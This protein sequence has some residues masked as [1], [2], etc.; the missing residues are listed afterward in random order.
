L[1]KAFSFLADTINGAIYDSPVTVIMKCDEIRPIGLEVVRGFDPDYCIVAVQVFL[2]LSGTD[3]YGTTQFKSFD[4]YQN[5]VN[6][7]CRRCPKVC[8]FLING[9]QATINGCFATFTSN[10]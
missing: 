1:K 9:C 8:L 10:N 5:F 3:T 6:S 4:D 7:K 2:V